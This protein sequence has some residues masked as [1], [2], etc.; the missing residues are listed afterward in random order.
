MAVVKKTTENNNIYLR[1]SFFRRTPPQLSA[2]Q[3]NE[4]Q[5]PDAK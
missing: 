3:G 2:A 4:F 5:T 1:G